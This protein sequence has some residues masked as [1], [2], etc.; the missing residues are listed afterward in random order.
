MLTH[1]PPMSLLQ[2]GAREFGVELTDAQIDQFNAYY[3][4]LVEWNARVNLTAI[5]G[6]SEVEVLHFLDSLSV[7]R[8]LPGLTG[9]GKPV[10]SR[11]IDVGAGGGFPGVPL[12]IAFPHLQVT[13]LEATGKKAIFLDFLTRALSLDNATVLKGRAED[14]GRR[15][16]YREQFDFATARAVAEL[17]TLVE[18]VLPFLR[19]GGI[20][21]ASKGADAAEESE[22]AAHAISALGGQ[23]RELI[24]IRL[25]T[26]NEPRY[27]VVVE[28]VTPTPD[29]Y[30]RRAGMP[31]KKPL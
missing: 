30:P 29:K 19:S 23:L 4:H 20:L 1:F 5:T 6:Y 9:F 3:R 28:K 8:A 11:L 14:L 24:P 26:L 16:E 13:L 15:A 21:A 27:L 25:P 17:R 7:A 31:E 18:Y 12:A 2:D 22:R 10:R